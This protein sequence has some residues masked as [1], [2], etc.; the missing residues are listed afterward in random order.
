MSTLSETP[1]TDWRRHLYG[2]AVPSG[3]IHQNLL[4][5]DRFWVERMKPCLD[6]T[7]H[8]YYPDRARLAGR[9]MELS[10]SEAWRPYRH[11]VDIS[12]PALLGQNQKA[13]LTQT[14][15]DQARIACALERHRLARGAYPGSLSELVPGFLD[16]V[17]T[18][19]PAGG[20]VRYHREGRGY[21]LYSL[22]TDGKD[23]HGRTVG[24]AANA[25]GID[26][27]QGDWAWKV[28]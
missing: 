19:V 11:L 16:A 28:D 2:M 26:P 9:A 24:H 21:V 20:A 4:F 14:G 3:W 6:P 27:D 5:R 15:L 18:D 12:F 23:E 8:R 22:G 17:P 7:L 1:G 25:S 10:D 13:A